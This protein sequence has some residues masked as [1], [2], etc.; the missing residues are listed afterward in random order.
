MSHPFPRSPEPEIMDDEEQ[1]RAYAEADFSEPHE[2]FVTLF[3][4]AFPGHVPTGTVLDLGCGPADVSIRFC[5]RYSLCRLHGVDGAPAMLRLGRDAVRRAGLNARI[6]LLDGYL[7]GAALPLPAYDALISNSLLHHLADPAVLWDSLRRWGKPGAPVFVMDL[8]RPAS[9][10]AAQELVEVHAAAAPEVLRRD[11]H[12][13]LCAAYRPEEIREQL[14]AAGL[15]WL[16]VD[17]VGDRHQVVFGR[18]GP[19]TRP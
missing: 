14:Q 6:R 5:R 10:A 17:V 18:L 3:G 19:K 2:H 15:P 8:L 16:Q 9:A 11:F 7:P 1:A 13:S 4:L 12:H